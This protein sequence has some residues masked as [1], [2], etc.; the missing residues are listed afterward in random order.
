[1]ELKTNKFNLCHNKISVITF[2]L[3]QIFR[4]FTYEIKSRCRIVILL[5]VVDKFKCPQVKE[6]RYFY[7]LIRSNKR[8]LNKE[9]M[10]RLN[11]SDAV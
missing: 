7:R 10:L 6:T 8:C 1:M 5:N 4:N 9:Y 11:T 2:F 3:D